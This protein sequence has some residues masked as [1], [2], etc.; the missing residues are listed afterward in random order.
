MNHKVTKAWED[1]ATLTK[2]FGMVYNEVNVKK[3]MNLNPYK[4]A[5]LC[6]V[7][8]LISCSIFYYSLGLHHQ[9]ALICEIL[10]FGLF[11]HLYLGIS[12]N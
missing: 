9:E 4:K 2:D 8:H 12:A 3:K 7:F 6:L 1:D 11:R 5:Q 10:A